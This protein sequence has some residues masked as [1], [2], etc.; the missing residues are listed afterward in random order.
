MNERKKLT[1]VAPKTPYIPTG[2]RTEKGAIILK[3]SVVIDGMI[4][5]AYTEFLVLSK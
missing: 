4:K 1:I 5:N 3:Q 2:L